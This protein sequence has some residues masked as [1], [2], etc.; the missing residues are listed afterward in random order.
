MELQSVEL[1][2]YAAAAASLYATNSK[3]IIPL[4]VA[5]MVA[6]VLVIAYA[7]NRGTY[8]PLLLNAMLLPLNAIRLRAMVK[9]INDVD[10]A[11]K[12]D[13]NVKWL[14]DY[15]SP[16]RFKAGDILVQRGEIAN[17]AFY[18]VS[19]EVEL[20]EIHKTVG[21]GT[22][23]GEVGLFTDDGRRTM[24]ARCATDVQAA[25]ITNDRFKELY[26]QN[27]QFGF[28]LLRLIVARMHSNELQFE[29]AAGAPTKQHQS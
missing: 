26:F 17:E 10:A 7:F 8:P 24:T 23:L 1:I 21:N 14:L 13:M 6:N 22:L 28:S 25:I 2:G 20:V 29:A 27:P 9:L 4:R 12:R 18:I 16:K 5:G 11:A 19:G 3:T 15:M